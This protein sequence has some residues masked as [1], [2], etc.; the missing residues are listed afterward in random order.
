MLASILNDYKHKDLD[1]SSTVGE[2]GEN[3]RVQE[4]PGSSAASNEH[5][6]RMVSKILSQMASLL[7]H[8]DSEVSTRAVEGFCKL[9]MTGHILSA[10]LFS[11][12]L[13]MYFSPLTEH[14]VRLRSVLSNFLPQFAFLRASNQVCVE[15]SFMITLKH[16]INAPPETHL[17]EIDLMKVMELLLQLTN[18]KNLAQQRRLGIARQT[19]IYSLF[20]SNY[21]RIIN[22]I[23]CF[24][25]TFVMRTLSSRFA[26]SC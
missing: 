14:D 9:Y 23:I 6:Q 16:L 4:P 17:A 8:E 3:S 12:L 11:K 20:C 13:I 21:T 5:Q 15:E 10:K 18:P 7:D 22:F 19:V 26:W 24:R 25:I 1:T 2:D